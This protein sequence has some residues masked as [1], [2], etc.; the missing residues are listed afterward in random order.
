MHAAELFKDVVF[1][2]ELDHQRPDAGGLPPYALATVDRHTVVRGGTAVIRDPA[3]LALLD[4]PFDPFARM[5]DFRAPR[6]GTVRANLPNLAIFL[7]RLAPYRI[8]PV[9]PVFRGTV[10]AVLEDGAAGRLV[11]F[12]LSPLGGPVRLFNPGTT[13]VD[14]PV[15]SG[16]DRA[17]GPIHPARLDSL[18]PPLHQGPAPPEGAGIGDLWL[19]TT[20]DVWSQFNGSDWIALD[21]LI[22][23]ELT[24]GAF[25]RP[26]AYVAV[27]SYDPAAGPP[28]PVSSWRWSCICPTARSAPSTPRT[29]GGAAPAW[30][31]GR[32][33]A[34]AAGRA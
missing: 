18:R 5:P 4:T 30:S 29:G 1:A 8:G 20:S 15:G 16:P 21:E 7:W 14:L 19:D 33:A 32:R 3:T 2:Q 31:R 27:A 28:A 11:R 6:I 23:D 9:Q 26:D 10:E 22:V 34:A 25:G 13:D 17:P 24:G 12:D